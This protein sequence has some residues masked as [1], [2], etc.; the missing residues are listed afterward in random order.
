MRWV[1][2]PME[3]EQLDLEGRK[4]KQKFTLFRM[5]RNS[6]DLNS[7]LADL[8]SLSMKSSPLRSMASSFSSSV[9]LPRNSFN[10]S[11]LFAALTNM[12]LP[13]SRKEGGRR[14]LATQLWIR[15]P[16]NEEI[17][18]GRENTFVFEN[19]VAGEHG[20]EWREWEEGDHSPSAIFFFPT[21]T[22]FGLCEW[23]PL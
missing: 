13:L 2:L 6:L 20:K 10:S 9:V 11:S 18:D 15:I 14:A 19:Q 1:L 7:F 8:W 3:V 4:I 17:R 16:W 12:R 5:R 21:V 23:K 22:S